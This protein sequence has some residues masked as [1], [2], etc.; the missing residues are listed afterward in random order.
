MRLI[1]QQPEQFKPNGIFVGFILLRLQHI[2]EGLTNAHTSL[3][4]LS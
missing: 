1:N 2:I 4:Q 3:V